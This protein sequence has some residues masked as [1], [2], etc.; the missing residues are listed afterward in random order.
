LDS[1]EGN[2]SVRHS[3]LTSWIGGE[4]ESGEQAAIS[5]GS[6]DGQQQKVG[7]H[8]VALVVSTVKL[9]PDVSGRTSTRDIHGT[10]SGSVVIGVWVSGTKVDGDTRL[11]PGVTY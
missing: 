2:V 3:G 4:A 1:G 11:P 5:W 9:L 6:V 10:T 7:G 8:I